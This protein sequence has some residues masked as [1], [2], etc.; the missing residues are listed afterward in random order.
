[1]KKK[2]ISTGDGS[3]SLYIE[4]LNET[5]HSKHGALTESSYVYIKKGLAHWLDQNNKKE[6]KVFE[7]GMGTGL[8]AYL[9]YVFSV[10][11]K[12]SC[13]YLSIEKYPL[14]LK[15]IRSLKMK[16]SLPAREHYHFFDQLHEMEW[17]QMFSQSDFF[18][19]KVKK[20]FFSIGLD[21][22]YDVL[23]YDAFGYH[24]QSNMW[25]ENALQICHEILKPGGV[26]VSY[27][28][29]GDVR[30]RLEKI[31]FSVERLEGPPGKREMLRAIKGG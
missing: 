23:F 3:P 31:G 22:S 19:K 29:K 20:D 2:I 13:E 1:M 24:A 7:L 12:I 14:S 25:Q 15:E 26:W 18:F 8:N 16:E 21:D 11:Q 27:C 28:A 10:N 4:E 17:N 6:L 5:Y 9:S 30:R